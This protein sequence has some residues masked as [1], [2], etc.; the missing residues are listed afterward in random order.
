MSSLNLQASAFDAPALRFLQRWQGLASHSTDTL[1]AP[2]SPEQARTQVDRL[3]WQ[4]AARPTRAQQAHRELDAAQ[5][6][7]WLQ[8]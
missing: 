1:A 8:A 4:L 2:D 6:A 7:R 5:V 3:L